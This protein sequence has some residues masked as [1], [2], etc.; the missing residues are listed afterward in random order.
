LI[1]TNVV[2]GSAQLKKYRT[3]QLGSSCQVVLKMKAAIFDGSIPDCIE[4][5]NAL[6]PAALMPA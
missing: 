5:Q 6:R 4:A 3:S 2:G 1:K